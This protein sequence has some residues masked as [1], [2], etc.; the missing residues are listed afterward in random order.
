[1]LKKHLI[2]E[3]EHMKNVIIVLEILAVMFTIVNNSLGIYG[4]SITPKNINNVENNIN[5]IQNI[6]I[7][8]NIIH[9][10]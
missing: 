2:M 9:I 8:N 1:M 5:T 3:N 10:H 6:E 7:Q 4:L